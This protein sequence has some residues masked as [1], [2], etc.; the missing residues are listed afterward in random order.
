MDFGIIAGDTDQTIYVRLRDSTTGLAKTGLAYNSAG[1]VA[2][3]TLPGA[4]RAAIT[5]ATQTV[6]GAHSDGG[7]VEVDATNCK[8]LY[9]LD[10]PDAAIASGKYSII[11]I[12]FDGIIEESI[13]VPLSLRKADVRQNA[14][15]NIT[16]ASGRQEVN[17]SH[18]AGSAVSTSSAQIGVNVVNAAGTAWGS[19]A[20]TAA[21][22]AADAITAAKIADGAIDANTFAAGAITASAIAADAIGASELA[23]DAV[24]EIQSGL[25]TAANLATVDTVVDAILAL[26]DD[27]RTEPG[28]GAPPV[29][30]DLATKIDYLYKA[31]RNKKTQTSSEY[32]LFADDASTV[33]QKAT[34]SDDGTTT[35]IGEVASGP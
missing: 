6:S 9:R 14:G 11:S 4:A 34:V 27:A 24:T 31:W 22:I 25:A 35:T 20:I 8:G 19:G 1:A 10:L 17:L 28:Q 32:N 29:N 7:F 15:T 5:L 2:S 33:D 12:E 16:S 23:A 18:I 21:S 3:Y 13:I 26:L 30:P